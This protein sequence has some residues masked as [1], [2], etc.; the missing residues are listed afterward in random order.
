MHTV[1]NQEYNDIYVKSRLAVFD[2]P[3]LR[4]HNIQQQVSPLLRTVR[5]EKNEPKLV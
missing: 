5:G 1:N 3:F 4:T 2:G